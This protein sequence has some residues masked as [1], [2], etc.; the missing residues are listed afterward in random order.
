VFVLVLAVLAYLVL[1]AGFQVLPFKSPLRHDQLLLVVTGVDL[2]LVLIGFLLKP[3]TDGI[4][5]VSIGWSIGAFLAL[6]AAIV[7]VAAVTP[8]GRERLDSG[9]RAAQ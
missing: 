4:A 6:V 2:L 5:G 1:V 9:A 3:S 7:A 8:P